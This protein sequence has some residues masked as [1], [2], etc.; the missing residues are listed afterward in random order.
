MAYLLDTCAISEFFKPEPNRGVIEWLDAQIPE[1]LFLSVLTIG[2]IR[3]GI[4]KLPPSKKRDSVTLWL[5]EMKARYHGRILGFDLRAAEIWGSMRAKAET[6]GSTLSMIDSLIA[7]TAVENGLVI[8]TRNE[9]DFAAADVRIF[10]P[11][12]PKE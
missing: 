1:S 9:K 10:N 11:W 3:K 6:N 8:V 12:E 4:S 5:D 2:E 7:A